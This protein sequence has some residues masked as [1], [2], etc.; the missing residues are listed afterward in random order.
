MFSHLEIFSLRNNTWK[1]LEASRTTCRIVSN[2]PKVGL[3]FNGSIHWSARRP[4]LFMDVIIAFDLMER[5]HFHIPFQI[6]FT[7]NL[8]IR[9]CGYLENLSVY[10]LRIMGDERIQNAFILDCAFCSSY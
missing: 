2:Q 5:T 1:E 3:F 9:A 7:M 4:D 8:G 6:V 10:L